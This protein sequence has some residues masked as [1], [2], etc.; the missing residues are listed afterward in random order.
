MMQVIQTFVFLIALIALLMGLVRIIINLIKHKPVRSLLWTFFLIVFSYTAVWTIFYL[1]HTDIPVPFGTN[2]CFDDWCATI[3]GTER[4]EIPENDSLAL[5]SHENWMILHVKM[6]N[7]AKRI[8]QKPCNPRVKIMDDRGII[9]HLSAEGQETLE[10][11]RGKQLPL[12]AKLE[13]HQSLETQM[14]FDIPAD[15]GNLKAVIEEGPVIT[16]LLFYSDRQIFVLE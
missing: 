14:V 1:K 10:K 13:L 15:S 3:T 8:A 11:L 4:L 2:I 6:I 16:R 5:K 7:Q 12:D 9:Y